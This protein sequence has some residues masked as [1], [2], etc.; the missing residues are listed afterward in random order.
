MV[1]VM[2]MCKINLHKIT[3]PKMNVIWEYFNICVCTNTYTYT[4]TLCIINEKEQL[5]QVSTVKVVER[6]YTTDKL[7]KLPCYEKTRKKIILG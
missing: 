3:A 7:T 2:V 1:F 4:D 5:F 6:K